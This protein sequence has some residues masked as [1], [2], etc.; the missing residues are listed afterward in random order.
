[1]TNSYIIQHE[2]M[3][4]IAEPVRELTGTENELTP[5]QIAAKV[6][7]ANNEISTQSNLLDEA[8]TALQNKAAGGVNPVIE[9]LEITVNGTYTAFD[10]VDGYSPITVNVPIPEGYIQPSGTLEVA[11]NGMHDITEYVSVNVNVPIPDGYIQPSGEL[12]VIE[13]GT[14]DVTQYASVNVNVAAAGVELPEG[15]S[16]I[17]GGTYTPTSDHTS[18]V[19]VE[20][21]LGVKPDFC[22]WV[23][24]ADVSTAQIANTTVAGYYTEKAA[25]YSNSLKTPYHSHYS[26]VAYNSSGALQRTASSVEA[27]AFTETTC[28]IMANAQYRLKAGCT[29]QWV[30]GVLS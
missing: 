20:H 26:M 8:I 12:E 28:C 11:E 15:I 2:T 23:L 21:N 6:E 14:H 9:S 22:W 10:G 4:S 1:M 25:I 16:A 18:A 13:N 27:P 3:F 24:M 7:E 29:Y 17:A 5:A 30:C 19:N